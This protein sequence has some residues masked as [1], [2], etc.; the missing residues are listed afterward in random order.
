MSYQVAHLDELDHVPA[1]EQGLTWRPVRRRFGVRAFGV[2]AYTAR[3]PGQEV[4]EDH[5]EGTNRHEELYVVLT[6]QATF[7]VGEERIDAPAGTLV[8]IRDPDVRRG[9]EA[10]EAGTTVLAI[11]ARA[12]E[13]YRPAAWEHWFIAYGQYGEDFERAIEEL[14]AGLEQH[15]D[16]PVMLYHL[17]CFESRAGRLDDALG[18]LE[19]AVALDGR[20]AEWARDDADLE[21]IRDD[22]RFVSAVTRQA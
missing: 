10:A 18:H 9:A 13:P 4:V 6:G 15:P 21:A 20:A 3:E 12:G 11:G 22:P 5:T 14:R 16:H 1:G 19:R 7:R 17:A 8:F 2:N